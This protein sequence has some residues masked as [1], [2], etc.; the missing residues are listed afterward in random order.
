METERCGCIC[1]LSSTRRTFNDPV[2]DRMD[3][4]PA[5][6]GKMDRKAKLFFGF[7][8][9]AAHNVISENDGKKHHLFGIAEFE[10]AEYIKYRMEEY[11]SMDPYMFSFAFN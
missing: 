7:S 5:S 9:Y 6:C 4:F 8:V 11:W 3:H 2:Y 10:S 1:G